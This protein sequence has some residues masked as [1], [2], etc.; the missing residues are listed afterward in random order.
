MTLQNILDPTDRSRRNASMLDEI[1]RIIQSELTFR[2]ADAIEMRFL[3]SLIYDLAFAF[4]KKINADLL[5]RISKWIDD[6]EWIERYKIHQKSAPDCGSVYFSTK[7]LSVFSCPCGRDIRAVWHGKPALRVFYRRQGKNIGGQRGQESLG[8]PLASILY[9]FYFNNT[10]C[11]HISTSVTIF[12]D[13][14]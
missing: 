11:K 3:R 7:V 10:I 8:R 4:S 12:L 6:P 2:K 5:N 1:R 13:L 9:H 14:R